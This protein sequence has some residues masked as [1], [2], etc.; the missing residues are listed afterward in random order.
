MRQALKKTKDGRTPEIDG[1]PAELYKADSD[2]AV[3]ELTRVLNRAWH[4]EKVAEQWKKGLI[5]K[6]TERGD[7]K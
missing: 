5:V 3:Q 1:I 4:H 6:I 2:V 7:L